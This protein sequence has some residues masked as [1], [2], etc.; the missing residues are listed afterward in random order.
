MKRIS[1]LR[2]MSAAM[3]MITVLV[4]TAVLPAF[5]YEAQSGPGYG[6]NFQGEELR[7][8]ANQTESQMMSF[9]ITSANGSVIVIDGGT[10]DDAPHLREQIAEK[11]NHVSAW[12]I[13]HPHSDHAGA[14]TRII[15]EGPDPITID[16]FYFNFAD[17]AWYQANESY[18]ADF[19]ERV[20]A[21][22]SRY[23]EK[24]HVIHRGDQFDFDTVHITCMNDPYLVADNAINNSSCVLKVEM[25]GKKIMFLGDMGA[26]VGNMFLNDHA[27]E[28]LKVDMVQMAHHGQAGVGRNFYEVLS[29]TVC[30]WCTPG[31]L[32]YDYESRYQ[33]GA[34]RSWMSA[35]G[36][37]KNYCIKDGDRILR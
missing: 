11:G 19:V 18:R 2:K 26:D 14:L 7:M 34:V 15:E 21:A 29:P 23:P 9:I 6:G 37:T 3:L 36:V 4:I 27:G 24:L 17:P 32:Y 20:R 31:W 30:L 35:M 22:I 10:E 1:L 25:G 16:G 28:D 13:T 8:L 5:A 33:T 12:F